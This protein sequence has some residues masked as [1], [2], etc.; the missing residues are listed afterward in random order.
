MFDLHDESGLAA[1]K[2]CGIYDEFLALTGECSEA[3][4]VA[5]KDGN[6]LYQDEGELSERVWYCC[7]LAVVYWNIDSDG[8]TSS[9]LPLPPRLLGAQRSSWTLAITTSKLST[10]SLAPMEPGLESGSY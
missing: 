2:E 5:D 4:K 8:V 6:I 3:Q 10:W 1:I 7:F 9:F